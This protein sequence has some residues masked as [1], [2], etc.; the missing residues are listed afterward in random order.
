MGECIERSFYVGSFYAVKCI[1]IPLGPCNPGLPFGP[2]APSSPFSPGMPGNP[3]GPALPT[4]L[5]S[6]RNL[7]FLVG[8]K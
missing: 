1:T 4:S 3:G 6:K 7:C 5:K 2:I 8:I